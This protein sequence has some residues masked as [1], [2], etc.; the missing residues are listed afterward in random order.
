MKTQINRRGFFGAIAGLVACVKNPK[1]IV[2]PAASAVQPTCMDAA[3]QAD[4]SNIIDT[5]VS[6]SGRHATVN[7]ANFF[8]SG[9]TV[10]V[11]GP[12]PDAP[13]RGT[14]VVSE[15]SIRR[16]E[17]IL[18]GGLLPSVGVGDLIVVYGA[19]HPPNLFDLPCYQIDGNTGL[20][21]GINRS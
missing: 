14:F 11:H 16:N 10:D 19:M 3:T 4:G 2:S 6:I 18:H 15:Q 17:I 13:Y 1:A 7:N 5:V 9:Q 8:Q 20:Y 21:M 12:L